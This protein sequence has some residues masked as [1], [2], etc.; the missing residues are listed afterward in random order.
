MEDVLRHY[1]KGTLPS[2]IDPSRRTERLGKGFE[3]L[4]FWLQGGR[5][6]MGPAKLDQKKTALSRRGTGAILA[7]AV[8]VRMA[9]PARPY[10]LPAIT[11]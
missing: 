3:F 11:E 4:G 5:R 1:K 10:L 9:V 7:A 8:P 6:V 2:E